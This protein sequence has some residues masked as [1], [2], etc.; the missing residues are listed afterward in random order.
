MASSQTMNP[1]VSSSSGSFEKDQ[2]VSA[3]ENRG[4]SPGWIPSL[5]FVHRVISWLPRSTLSRGGLDS[6][7]LHFLLCVCVYICI[8]G[9]AVR[10]DTAGPLYFLLYVCVCVCVF[11]F[12]GLQLG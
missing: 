9:V 4:H 11:V 2:H 3:A 5:D 7:G 6:T 1:Q 12:G 8:W 10:I